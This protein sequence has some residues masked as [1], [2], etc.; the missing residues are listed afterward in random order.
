MSR[1]ERNFRGG[2]KIVVRKRSEK[3]KMSGIRK[4]LTNLDVARSTL[5]GQR[6]PCSHLELYHLKQRRISIEKT[7][8]ERLTHIQ[9]SCEYIQIKS[10]DFYGFGITILELINIFQFFSFLKSY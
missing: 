1:G 3:C 4:R 9:P 5:Q 7:L 2:R 8:L 6:Y 10:H